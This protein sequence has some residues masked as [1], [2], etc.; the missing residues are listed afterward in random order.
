MIKKL[1]IALI[2]VVALISVPGASALRIDDRFVPPDGVQGQ[3]YFF[4]LHVGEGS[5]SYP[6]TW[7][8]PHSGV[9]PPGLTTITSKDTRTLTILGVPTTPVTYNFFVQL[10]DAP[11]PWVCCT[12]VPYTI[13]IAPP[14][15]PPPPG[16][17]ANLT[18]DQF[19]YTGP[20]YG[21]DYPRDLFVKNKGKGKGNTAQA[22]KLIM[23][24]LDLG[25]FP[26]PDKI[27]NRA[28]VES[29]RRFQME[30]AIIPTGNYGK[31]TWTAIREAHKPNGTLAASQV[32]RLLVNLEYQASLPK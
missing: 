3:G 17:E 21:P 29:V 30:H 18:P 15:A 32:A 6:M 19:P 28:L 16:Q 23:R 2:A 7:V 10:R 5:G 13:V 9:F 27:Y 22:L 26:N 4:Q 14:N 8:V 12:E 31:G 11:G 25:Y 24:Q 1:L 20:Y